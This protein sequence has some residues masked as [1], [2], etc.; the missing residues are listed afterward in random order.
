MTNMAP[1]FAPAQPVVSSVTC[2]HCNAPCSPG[3]AFLRRLGAAISLA[4]VTEDFEISGTA[5]LCCGDKLCP[6]VWRATAD[7]TW[8]W[9]DVAPEV[10]LTELTEAGEAAHS[11]AAAKIVTRAVALH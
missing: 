11:R 2:R 6:A 9:G 3:L 4:P 7:G 10:P 1:A 8:L 5:N